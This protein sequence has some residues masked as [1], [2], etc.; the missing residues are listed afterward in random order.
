MKR[1]LAKKWYVLRVFHVMPWSSKHIGFIKGH[2]CDD[3]RYNGWRTIIKPYDRFMH[4][5]QADYRKIKEQRSHARLVRRHFHWDDQ[6]RWYVIYYS[7]QIGDMRYMSPLDY[8]KWKLHA[9]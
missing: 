8:L 7:R 9:N 5:P 3:C 1:R 4:P 2:R 6:A